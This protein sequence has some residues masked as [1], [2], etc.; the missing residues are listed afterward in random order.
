MNIG[1][2]IQKNV[3]AS[4]FKCSIFIYQLKS[5]LHSKIRPLK[6]I[7]QVDTYM[8]VPDKGKQA[9]F[10]PPRLILETNLMTTLITAPHVIN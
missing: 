2:Y 5:N 4:A 3:S 1:S 7:C 8:Y 10:I 6:P 9:F